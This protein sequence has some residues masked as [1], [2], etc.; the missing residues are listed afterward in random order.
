MKYKT[1]IKKSFDSEHQGKIVV[2]NKDYT[3]E[4]EF[5]PADLNKDGLETS[6]E[7]S[8]KNI[9]AKG[10]WEA[11]AE[12][13]IG[14]MEAGPLTFWSE[15]QFNTDDKKDHSLT[16]SQNA[17]MDKKYHAAVK[18]VTS[19]GAKTELQELYGILAF[20]DLSFGDLWLRSNV[21]KKIHSIGVSTSCDTHHHSA[22]LQYDLGNK[23]HEGLFG[24]PLFYRHGSCFHMANKTKIMT[25]M[26]IGKQWWLTEKLEVPLDDKVKMTVSN[27]Y[28]LM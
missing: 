6:L 8:Y 12:F 4:W 15:L 3:G 2:S 19:M 7:A 23:N 20:T 17:V 26:N 24:M 27:K 28:D 16:V 9:P 11:E 13:K 10:N 22:E 21:Q 18:A 25:Q 5:K 1:E 14:G